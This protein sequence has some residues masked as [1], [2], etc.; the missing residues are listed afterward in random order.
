MTLEQLID[1]LQRRTVWLQAERA[2]AVDRGDVES[3]LA[4]DADLTT[5]QATLATLTA[6]VG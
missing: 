2:R 3:V 6:A 5:T 4:L 1:L